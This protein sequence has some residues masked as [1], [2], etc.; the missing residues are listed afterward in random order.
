MGT[1]QP[2]LPNRPANAHKGTFGHVVAIAGSRCMPGAAG[3]VAMAAARTG[4]GLV[5]VATPSSAQPVIAG[6]SPVYMSLPVAETKEGWIAASAMAELEIF[7]ARANVI[8]I[9]PGLGTANGAR[10]VVVELY[11]EA[12]IPIVIDADG[13]NVLAAEAVELEDHRGPRILTPHPGE[14]RRLLG[15]SM[16]VETAGELEQLEDAAIEM[17]S[18]S[19]IVLVAKSHRTL[20]TDGDSKWRSSGGNSGMATGGTGDVLTGIIAS[21]LAQGLEPL[22]AAVSGTALHALAGNLAAQ[23]LGPASMIATDLVDHLSAAFRIAGEEW[24][25]GT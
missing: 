8:A 20:V 24:L 15:V 19:K 7:L 12:T 25:S 2:Q 4:C 23:N 6:Y 21:L 3:L 18:R 16:K 13:L 9:G 14:L 10:R 17:A 1:P 5:T 11:R 22:Q